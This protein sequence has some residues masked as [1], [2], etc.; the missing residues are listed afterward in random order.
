MD[1]IRA[2]FC[3]PGRFFA[4]RDAARDWQAKHS[5]MEVLSVMDAYRAS[6]GLSQPF[7]STARRPS[8]RTGANEFLAISA[9]C[10]VFT[11]CLIC[12][13]NIAAIALSERCCFKGRWVDAGV[14]TGQDFPFYPP[15]STVVGI[16][17]SPAMLARAEHRKSHSA[18]SIELKKM[19]VTA[20]DFP[21]QSFDGAVAAPVQKLLVIAVMAHTGL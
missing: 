14:G 18:V 3:N 10:A 20:L 4:S 12:H 19:D 15:D 6:R 5:R 8:R 1:S 17:L 2:A 9:D 7:L 21:D 16:D 11:I 13:S